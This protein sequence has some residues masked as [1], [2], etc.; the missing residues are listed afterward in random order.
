MK[1]WILRGL[2]WG[3][4]MVLLTT[5]FFPWLDD[6]PIR[7]SRIWIRAL[8]HIPMGLALFWGLARL[9]KDK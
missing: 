5:F 1:N 4:G 6:E 9:Q 3:I 7:W 2:F 8:L